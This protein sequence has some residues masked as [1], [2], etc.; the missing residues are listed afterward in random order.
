MKENYDVVDQ[1]DIVTTWPNLIYDIS[2]D[3]PVTIR[4]VKAYKG[5]HT[6]D[7][8]VLQA[9]DGTMYLRTKDNTYVRLIESE[10]NGCPECGSVDIF[11][12]ECS[13]CKEEFIAEMEYIDANEFGFSI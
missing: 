3:G 5:E 6:M 12:M 2:E 7:W 4:I 8:R 9:D 13:T 11:N 10:K 1:D